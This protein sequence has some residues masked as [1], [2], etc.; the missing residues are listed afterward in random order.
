[1]QSVLSERYTLRDAAAFSGVDGA[2][3]RGWLARSVVERVP[4]RGRGPR[5]TFA[6]LVRAAA[7]GA[8]QDIV[9][10]K[11]FKPGSLAALLRSRVSDEAVAKEV[12]AA[13][14][15]HPPQG[16]RPIQ[17]EFAGADDRVVRI[18]RDPDGGRLTVEIGDRGTV[19]PASPPRAVVQVELTRLVRQLLTRIEAHRAIG[20]LGQAD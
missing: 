3:L 13:R 10:V 4:G 17:H 7:L 15:P 14:A 8:I 20:G 5:V 2:V 19:R 12:D 1:M 9:G 16:R 18:Y 6:E 11:A